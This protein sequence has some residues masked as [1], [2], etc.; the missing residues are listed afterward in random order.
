MKISIE[1][2]KFLFDGRLTYSELPEANPAA[3]GRLMNSRMVQAT[4]EDLNPETQHLF[5]YPDGSPYAPERQTREFIAM[6]PEYRRHGVIAVTV[7]FQGGYP[8]PHHH[9]PA[10]QILQP[11][12]NS[13]F[14][15]DGALRP[16]Y[17]ARM[18][19]AIEALDEQRMVAI[20]G[21]FYFGQ[22]HRLRDE[23]AVRRAVLEGVRF[24]HGLGRGNIIVEINN[25]SDIG[26][27]HPIL[28]PGR[29][30]ELIALA[31]EA[32]NDELP[33][34]TSFGGGT[35]PPDKVIEASDLVLLHGNGQQPPNIYRMVHTVR[36]KTGKPIVFN[37]D[38]TRIPNLI[39]AW[40]AGASWGY[41]DQGWEKYVDGFQSPPTNWGI[42]SPAKEAFFKSVAA[43]INIDSA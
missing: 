18:Q 25:E 2:D 19:R 30:H 6:L 38:S 37:E 4:F 8:L 29:V 26:Y 7:N 42:G 35:I 32:T 40:E 12:I 11:W 24:L 14:D 31:R 23:E 21:L 3:H 27:V 34:T 1:E 17:A 13:G 16:A 10:G 28:Q 9:I 15:P 36:R 5:S 39:A 22:N 43:L 20:V 41:Y 33:V